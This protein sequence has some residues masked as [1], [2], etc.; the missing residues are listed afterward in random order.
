MTVEADADVYSSVEQVARSVHDAVRSRVRSPFL[1]DMDL[2]TL[3]SLRMGSRKQGNHDLARRVGLEIVTREANAARRDR[4]PKAHTRVLL[5]LTSLLQETVG[6][7]PTPLNATARA[8]ARELVI[9]MET[10][11][12]WVTRFTRNAPRDLARRELHELTGLELQEWQELAARLAEEA[13]KRRVPAVQRIADSSTEPPNLNVAARLSR[14][15]QREDRAAGAIPTYDM[16]DRDI[17]IRRV[18]VSGFRGSPGAVSVDFTKKGRPVDVLL[19]GDNGMGKS[20][21]VDGIEFALQRR[22]DRSADFNGTLRPAVRNLSVPE[23]TACVELSDGSTVE[24]SLVTN[25]AGRDEASTFEVRPGFRVA[26]I[27]IRRADIL[28]F[29]DTE[30]LSR[31]TVFFDYFPDPAGVLGMRPDEELKSLE[32]ERFVLRVVRDDAASQL[33]DLYPGGDED[34]T[35]AAR[36]EEFV[37]RLVDEIPPSEYKNV[38]DGLP[39]QAR[40]LIA[41]LRSTQQRLSSIKKLLDRGVQTLNPVAYRSQLERVVPI[42]QTVT[43]ELTSSF[44]RVARATHVSALRVLVAKSGPVSLDVVVEFDGGASALPQQVF[45][46]GY[47]DLIAL[48][49]FLA[50]TQKASEFGQAKVLVLDDALQSVDATVRLGVMDLVLEQ[51]SDWQLI[52]TGH[53]RAWLEQLRGLFARRGRNFVERRISAWSFSDGIEVTGSGRSRADMLQVGLDQADERMAASAAGLLLEELSQELSW[54]MCVSVTRR[55]G[56]KYTLGDLWPGVA[57]SL[58]RTSVAELVSAIDLRLDIRN[59]LGAHFNAWADEIPWSDVRQL[60]DDVLALFHATYCK[61]C[62][63]WVEAVGRAIACRC[64]ALALS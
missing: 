48:L 35:N 7:K 9:G 5:A 15:A 6:R 26:P 14:L 21:L 55:P 29:L 41:E 2:E 54:R 18:S 24:R 63:A 1:D 64:G 20:T 3:H 46:E 62:G 49:F 36:L 10:A 31:G 57:K 38:M 12:P 58:R 23:A 43:S 40:A 39:T 53:D 60:G 50:V 19:W 51:F 30:G 33:R 61:A 34:L 42:L 25:Q 45:S 37:E 17:R 59:L 28:R 47:K 32:E 27:V 16:S 56:D 44:K 13:T 22:V 8:M 11:P 52:V 4:S